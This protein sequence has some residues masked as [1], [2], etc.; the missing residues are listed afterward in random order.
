MVAVLPFENLSE[1]GRWDRLARGVTEEVI[2]DLATNPWLFVLAD[3]TTR[4]HA[5]A[6]PQAVG[7]AL[8]AG[9]VV[10]GTL[11]AEDGRVRIAAALADP[12]SGR[13]VWARQWEGPADDLLVLQTAA[14]E[15]LAGELAGHWSGAIAL[16]DR[17]RAH[18]AST[19]S[20]DAYDL[21]LL[22]IEHKHRMTR[23]DFELA[24]DYLLRAVAIDP[25][26]AKAW[27]SLS[28]VMGF[29]SNYATDEA[30][31][32]E[33]LDRLR[34]FTARAVAADPDDPSTLLEVSRLA[35]M[36]GDREAAER[37]IRR[38]VERAPNDADIL[39]VAA[40]MGPG[41]GGIHADAN[42]W[43][44]RAL[45]LNPAAPGWYM[46]AKG[47]A[48]FAAGDYTGRDRRDARGPAGFP[49]SMPSSSP[50]PPRSSATR[51][52]PRP[53]PGNCAASCPT[54]S[55]TAW[56]AGAGYL[57]EGDFKERL[58]DGAVLAGLEAPPAR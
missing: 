48:A 24:E 34:G 10:T 56:T 29:K 36:D 33:L 40:W 11:Q 4:P 5:G 15:A 2:A 21:Y 50:R 49:G 43:A 23:P 12:G 25:D 16:A 6:T 7:A 46:L 52:P 38:A 39:A 35:A 20:L 54:S 14:A 32:A 18:E 53:P 37:A 58:R 45:A 30:E 28:I 27:V 8:G 9:H 31:V 51:R 22:G 13:Q 41:Y 55:F 3:A 26:F 44:D 19:M 1:P 57:A 17:A 47:T 42:A